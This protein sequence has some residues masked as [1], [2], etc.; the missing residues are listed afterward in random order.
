[1]RKHLSAMAIVFGSG[2]G[3]LNLFTGSLGMALLMY[4]LVAINFLTYNHYL[5]Q[6]IESE[7]AE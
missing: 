6:E 3:F 7:D 1:M 2:V 5:K 4:G